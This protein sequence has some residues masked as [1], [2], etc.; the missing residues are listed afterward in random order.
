M[1]SIWTKTCRLPS[2]LAL[3]TD[4]DTDVAI[5]G[6][7]LTGLL[8]AYLLKNSGLSVIVLERDVLGRGATAFTTAKITSQHG[9]IYTKLLKT[10]GPETARQYAA[11]GQKAI[12]SYRQIIRQEKISCDFTNRPAYL[13]SVLEQDDLKREE[14]CACRL[15]LPASFTRETELPFSVAGAVRFEN[16]AQFHPLKFLK[17]I[18]PG[19]TVYEHSEVIRLREHRLAVSTPSGI[20]QVRARHIILTTHFP[21]KNFPGFYF[22][23]QHQDLSYVLALDHAAAIEGMYYCVDVNGHSLRSWENLLLFG[24]GGHR[25]G[26]F[27]PGDSYRRLWQTAK[28]WYPRAAAVSHWS[29]EDAM[30]HDS[31]PLIGRFSLWMQDVYVATGF[32]KWGMTNA[33]TAASFLSDRILGRP[34]EYDSI[35][36]PQ[37]LHPAA[38]AG[39]FL[40]DACSTAVHLLLQ[41]PFAPHKKKQAIAK[42][43]GP[44]CTHLGCTLS[45]NPA[46]KT[47]DCPCH[48][49]RYTED[50][51]LLAGPAGKSL[52]TPEK[53]QAEK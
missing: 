36:S 35:Y 39:P 44:V 25:T 46:D 18:L 22:L 28:E 49:S 17:G 52:N 16:Q 41:K 33:M 42:G 19:L 32:R 2:F 9:L 30:P 37:R 26:K 47:W 48:G 20:R 3:D 40:N 34:N 21:V 11:N 13:Y 50:G 29:N 43:F 45:W 7:G 23:R 14:E 53:A 10:L 12:A 51:T 1:E 5:V 15:G 4:L 38:A 27:H 8:T 24:G 6:G 31:L